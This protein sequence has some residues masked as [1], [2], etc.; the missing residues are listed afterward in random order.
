MTLGKLIFYYFLFFTKYNRKI[1][2]LFFLKCF[3]DINVKII[4]WNDSDEKVETLLKINKI[5]LITTK[6]KKKKTD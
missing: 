2:H 6:K 3:I 1:K 4:V 5:C